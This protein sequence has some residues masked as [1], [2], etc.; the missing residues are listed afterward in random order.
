VGQPEA[1]SLLSVAGGEPRQAA[2]S[3]MGETE[4]PFDEGQVNGFS[5][6]N[7][8][9]LRLPLAPQEEI[10]GLGLD[11]H[12]VRRRGSIQTLRVDHWGGTSGRTHAPVPFYV[13][14]RGYGVLV[15]SARYLTFYVG[16]SLR[17]GAEPPPEVRDRNRDSDW[18]AHPPSD[19]IDVHVPAGG[20]TVYVFA[21]PTALDAVRRYVLFSGGGCLPPKWGLGFT[22]RTPT[23]YTDQQ[24]LAEVAEF[25]E[26]GFPLDFVG[27]EPGW[28]SHAY[29]CSFEWDAERFPDPGAFVAKLLAKGVRVNLWMN[30]YV[31]PGTKL[32]RALAP[33]AAS[34]HVWNGIVPDYEIAEARDLFLSHLQGETVA[35]GV[36]GFKVDEVDGYDRWLWPDVTRFPS[37]N[38]AE[39]MRQTY[40][41]RL[42]RMLEEAYRSHDRRT[43]GLVRAS[44]AGAS[45]FPF[46][47]YNDHYSHQDFI[48]ALVNSSF[49]GVLWTPEVRGSKSGEEWLR[50]MQTVCFSPMAMLNAWASGTK[51][52]SFEEVTEEVR[53]IALL[54]MRLLPYLYT[55]FARYAEDGTPPFERCRWCP[56][57]RKPGRQLNAARSS[58]LSSSSE[59]TCWWHRFSPARA[60]GRW[61]SRRAAGSISGPARKAAT[62]RL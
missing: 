46:V 13:S 23:R 51:P 9:A 29:P 42:Q 22:H 2:L 37:G 49:C 44:N 41:V 27:V 52:W 45:R 19:S 7:R 25:E 8:C 48:T 5:E 18:Q 33:F 12:K 16:T 50:R 4:F 34:H 26:R 47:I 39:Q 11:F 30:P 10:Y 24:L 6:N 21:G 35:I 55:A 32:H 1:L 54:R 3:A 53:E 56:A 57:S 43:F 38:D 31:C 17:Q 62:A 58:R 61:F 20:A 59:R 14:D 40:G 15:D 60:P 36:S 28:H